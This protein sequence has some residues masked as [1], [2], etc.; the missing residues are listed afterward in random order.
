[1]SQTIPKGDALIQVCNI[2]KT[3]GRVRALDSVFLT[4]YRNE[5]LG[6]LGPN[7]SGKTTLLRILATLVTPDS[8]STHI[9]D[10][11]SC[12]IAGH[13]IFTEGPKVRHAIG[14]VPQ[15]DSL[16]TDLSAQDNLIFFTTPHALRHNHKRVAE[17]LQMAGLYDRRNALVSTLSG[18]MAKRLSVMCA[19][20][21]EPPVMIF[22]EATVG[23]DAETRRDIWNLMEKLKQGRA[24]IATTHYIIE[25]EEYCDRVALIFEG[26][27]L[28]VGSPAHL[29]AKYPPARNLDEAVRIAHTRYAETKRSR[30]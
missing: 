13:D 3:F 22:D 26:K 9:T 20:A 16:Y 2:S 25:A 27:V 29:V 23:L 14:Y 18:G 10:R 30:P 1:M 12:T 15:Q 4:V 7:G 24:I 5:I 21:H 11:V 19:L 28:D 8:H 17:L 6:L